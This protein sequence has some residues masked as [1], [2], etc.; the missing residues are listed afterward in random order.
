MFGGELI[1]RPRL[2]DRPPGAKPG[3]GIGGYVIFRAA[4]D[5]AGV[6][7]SWP[8]WRQRRRRKWQPPGRQ[9]SSRNVAYGGSYQYHGD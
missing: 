3:L 2:V 4:A 6:A 1:H 8:A 5:G 9:A 7:L